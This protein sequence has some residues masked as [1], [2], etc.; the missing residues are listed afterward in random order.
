M[1]FK[2]AHGAPVAWDELKRS[3]P[4]NELVMTSESGGKKKQYART[5]TLPHFCEPAGP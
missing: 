3:T 4:Q 2:I 5:H 1:G